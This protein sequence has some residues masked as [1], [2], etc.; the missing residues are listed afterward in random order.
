VTEI[1]L[2]HV[3]LIEVGQERAI[4]HI[5]VSIPQRVQRIILSS[6]L[7]ETFQIKIVSQRTPAIQGNQGD[8]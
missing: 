1:G 5:H 4:H 6:S 3:E 8:L 2:R 7:F